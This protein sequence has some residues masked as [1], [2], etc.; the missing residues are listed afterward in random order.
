MT[1]ATRIADASEGRSVNLAVSN[2]MVKLYKELFGRGPTKARTNFAGPD[3][4][5]TSLEDTFTPSEKALVEMG[6]LQRLRDV[7]M[8]FQYASESRFRETVEQITGRTVVGFVSG[9]D[10]SNDIAAELFYLE[11]EDGTIT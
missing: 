6:E 4:L 7:R 3:L 5:I 8:F 2:A 9:L 1:D 11:P 10:A